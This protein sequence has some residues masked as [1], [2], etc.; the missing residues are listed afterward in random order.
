[1]A[2]QVGL[3]EK[4]ERGLLHQVPP[5]DAEERRR[6]R[7]VSHVNVGIDVLWTAEEEAQR[8]AEVA[9]REAEAERLR[10]ANE[11]LQE[12]RLQRK[13]EIAGRIGLTTDELRALLA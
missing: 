2:G 6:G 9:A 10:Q 11:Q 4:D 3:F 5:E 13:A 7:L 1:M 8:Q 12:Q